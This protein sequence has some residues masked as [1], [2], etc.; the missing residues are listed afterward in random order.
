M[1]V[2]VL[3]VA[4]TPNVLGAAGDAWVRFLGGATGAAVAAM[5]GLTV[6]TVAP[7]LVGVRLIGTRDL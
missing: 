4:G 6:W 7:L 3:S 5:A 1:R 2:V